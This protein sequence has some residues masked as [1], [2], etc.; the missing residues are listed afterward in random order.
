MSEPLSHP[1]QERLEGYVEGS[2]PDAERAVVD[3][4]LV[5]CPRCRR[6]VDEW[7]ALFDALA[8]V[9]RPAPAADFANRVMA[10]VR[11]P[12]PWAERLAALV[13][14]LVPR[15]TRA[16][17]LAAAFLALPIVAIG[18]TAA[19]LL[20]KP[21]ITLQGLWIFATSRGAQAL[22]SFVGRAIGALLET[23][24][25]RWATETAQFMVA[26]LEPSQLV[27]G[28]GV[29]AALTSVSTWILY[30]YLI[31]TPTRDGDYVSYCF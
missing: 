29:L 30:R 31:R 22:A 26:G 21:W 19:W 4:H 15:S 10:D 27:I 1:A 3:S 7:E 5:A 20:S 23:G 12:K 25:G 13:R 18:G 16:W 6:A 11:V 28:L 9:P 14:R 8:T 17:A 2:L 24:A